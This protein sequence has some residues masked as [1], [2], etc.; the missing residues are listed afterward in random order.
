MKNGNG[1]GFIRQTFHSFLKCTYATLRNYISTN[2]DAVYHHLE[3]LRPN[4]VF[5]TETQVCAVLRTTSCTS[6]TLYDSN[7]GYELD[8]TFHRPDFLRADVCCRF[9]ASSIGM[10]HM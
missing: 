7:S 3:A 2:L 5:L 6:N 4:L 10:C 1:I 8:L 9:L